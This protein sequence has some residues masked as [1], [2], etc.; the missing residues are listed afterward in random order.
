MTLY[1]T[2][3][4]LNPNYLL[5]LKSL[6]QDAGIKSTVILLV[7]FSGESWN[8]NIRLTDVASERAVAEIAWQLK[9]YGN[10]IL[11]IWNEFNYRAIDYAKIIKG[12]DPGR[13]VTNSPGYGGDLG[14]PDENRIMDF[15]SPHTTRDDN[16][17]WEIAATEVD[18]LI[19][20]YNKPVV[21]DE[22]A[23]KG[24]SQF[25]GPK[26]QVY[27][28]DHILHIYNV[29][30]AGGYIIY[31]HDMFQTGAGSDA[32]PANGIPSPGFSTYHDS[33]FNFLRNKE[34]YLRLL[35][36]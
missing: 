36:K 9:P 3:G 25:G 15:L 20:K 4:S 26:V 6:I 2:D 8:E 10:V 7:L 23:R 22:P 21:D 17:H 19:R 5:R 34:R 12:I 16:R 32:V 1:N 13:L 33:V 18:Y 30:K 24:T 14:L 11:Q 31:H 35:R 27:P 29:W 28:E